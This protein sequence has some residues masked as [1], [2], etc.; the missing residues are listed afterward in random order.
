MRLQGVRRGK[1][2]DCLVAG[3]WVAVVVEGLAERDRAVVEVVEGGWGLWMMLGG[4]NVGV[5][6][7]E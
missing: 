1:E 3:G 5:V 7:E 4:R 6:V 2:V